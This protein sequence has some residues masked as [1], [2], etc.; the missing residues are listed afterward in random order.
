MMKAGLVRDTKL[1]ASA[2]SFEI[3]WFH[4]LVSYTAEKPALAKSFP[5]MSIREDEASK[6]NAKSAVR[7]T[8]FTARC[9]CAFLA[10]Q[11]LKHWRTSRGGRRKKGDFS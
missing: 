5:G 7:L 4:P 3:A 2:L 9:F 10:R 1:S 6:G 8:L 11:E